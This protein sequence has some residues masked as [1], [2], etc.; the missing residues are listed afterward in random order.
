MES[1]EP[2][3]G[4]IGLEQFK[5]YYDA[6]KSDIYRF[7]DAPLPTYPL[8]TP[9]TAGDFG[10]PGGKGL[11]NKNL[12]ALE[13]QVKL[14][15]NY[16]NEEN[17]KVTENSE[18]KLLKVIARVAYAS[19]AQIQKLE[20]AIIRG[21]LAS[22]QSNQKMIAEFEEIKSI[23]YSL[24]GECSKGFKDL[25]PVDGSAIAANVEGLQKN[26]VNEL[27][28]SEARSNISRRA[29]NTKL[30]DEL[31][32][33]LKSGPSRRNSNVGRCYTKVPDKEILM[34]RLMNNIE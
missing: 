30:R 11:T 6:A 32:I 8:G 31:K 21:L 5:N 15:G 17:R 24:N 29:D 20:S 16:Y 9:P 10:S 26:L 34:F 3:V 19:N 28:S 12:T 2:I 18:A 25:I 33:H 4:K 14:W 22:D 23:L 7:M 13:G 27:V 1:L